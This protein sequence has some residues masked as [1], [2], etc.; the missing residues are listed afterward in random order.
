MCDESNTEDVIGV[1]IKE[2]ATKLEASAQRVGRDDVTRSKMLKKIGALEGIAE[3]RDQFSEV[4]KSL[5]AKLS[6][7]QEELE[8]RQEVIDS[9][10]T[11]L[12]CAKELEVKRCNEL[13]DKEKVTARFRAALAESD[14][15]IV[16]LKKD[17]TSLRG[18][19]DAAL[20][21]RSLASE[22][23]MKQR[24][25][26]YT[27]ANHGL[28]DTAENK[29]YSFSNSKHR[30]SM[31]ELLNLMHDKLGEQEA[32]LEEKSKKIV[33]LELEIGAPF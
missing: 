4:N 2:L 27:D 28:L 21:D 31:L 13:E 17:N 18:K 20:P 5:S 10:V 32:E 30:D 16:E 23:K 11:D 29:F 7:A 22:P 24:F 8:D 15:L 12:K 1:V 9:F 6:E 25:I 19:L 3:E 14:V 26:V 33:D